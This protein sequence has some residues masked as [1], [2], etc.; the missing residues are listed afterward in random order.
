VENKFSRQLKTLKKIVKQLQGLKKHNLSGTQDG[1]LTQTAFNAMKK[2]VDITFP[3]DSL[4]L[5]RREK[6]GL[7][8][9]RGSDKHSVKDDYAF[10]WKHATFRHLPSRNFFNRCVKEG[11]GTP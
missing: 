5:D 10:L 2:L 9:K 11:S 4:V 1:S 3:S 8:C 6:T 7:T